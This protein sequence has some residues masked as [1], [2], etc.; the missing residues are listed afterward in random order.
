MENPYRQYKQKLLEIREQYP[1][2]H[3]FGDAWALEI[4]NQI[5]QGQ[6]N[7]FILSTVPIQKT[8]DT[9]KKRFPTFDVDISTFDEVEVQIDPDNVWEVEKLI[10]F[11][12]G[13]GWY[14]AIIEGTK[15]TQQELDKT[16]IRVAK[17]KV[18]SFIIFEKKFDEQEDVADFYYHITPDIYVDEI[19]KL[20][21]VPRSHSK[22]TSH[23]ER[24]Y[25]LNPTTK[26][27]VTG[28][29]EMLY[30]KTNNFVKDNTRYLQV[31]LVHTDKIKNL[32]VFEDP[33]FLIGNGAVWTQKNIPPT[34]LEKSFQIQ[35][36]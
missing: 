12:D 13:F 19:D 33:N 1:V 10:T 21:L 8:V 31:Y 28:I 25:L 14:P 29:G 11:L 24:I 5:Q 6:L 16:L 20:G 9:L 26:K 36:R 35:I 15:F 27:E 7:E 3:R 32:E 4:Y 22:L 17:Y 2:L 18:S 30:L 23:P 34:A